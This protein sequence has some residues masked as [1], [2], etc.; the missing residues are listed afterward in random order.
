MEI[1]NVKVNPQDGRYTKTRIYVFPTGESV[2]ENLVNRRARPHSVYR[3]EVLPKLFAQLGWDAGTKVKWS[4]YAGC[5]CPC[6][7]GFIVD[8]VYG[9]N[10]FVDVV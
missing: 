8:S 6:S 7:P 4:Q 1:A 5:S 3:K 2:M 10:V 9:K